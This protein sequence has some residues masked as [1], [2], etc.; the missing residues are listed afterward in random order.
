M[1]FELS[2]ANKL[3]KIVVSSMCLG[4]VPV[5]V[6]KTSDEMSGCK[7]I[8]SMEMGLKKVTDA[9]VKLTVE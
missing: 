7:S 6:L 3:P 8:E 9:L 5:A 2:S 1:M 4:L